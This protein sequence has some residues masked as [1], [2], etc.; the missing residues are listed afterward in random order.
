M[1]K[2]EFYKNEIGTPCFSIKGDLEVLNELASCNFEYLEEIVHSLEKVLEGELQYYDFG[3]EIY[4]IESKK[5]IAQI[6]D[7]YDYWKCIAEIPTQAI[8]LLMKDWRN[9]LINNPVITENTNVV[10]DLEIP[11]N[12]IFFDGIK[13]HQVN[14]TY[15]DWLSSPDYSV[16]SNSY[17]EV[18]DK[19]IY[20]IKENVK[21]LST[22]RYFNKEKLELLAQKYNLKIKE[23]YEILY[24]YT[25]NQSSS[26]VLEISQ[27]DQLTVIYSLTGRNAPE[28]IFIYGV[29]EN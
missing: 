14:S 8:Y 27:N 13:S 21:V 24:A 15:N 25:D 16:W 3:H 29:F 7:T 11:F 1:I 4:S 10:N 9:Y 19:R 5:E 23:E 17:V 2:Y 26:R 22:F 18:Q 20:I 28:G 6:V 12:Y